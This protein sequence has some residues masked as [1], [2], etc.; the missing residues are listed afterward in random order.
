MLSAVCTNCQHSSSVPAAGTSLATCLPWFHGVDRHGGVQVIGRRHHD[1]VKVLALAQLLPFVLRAGVEHGSVPRVFKL[2]R[3][4]L[5]PFGPQVAQGLDFNPLQ[6]PQK[7]HVTRPPVAH[8]NNAHAH[9]ADPGRGVARHVE[10]LLV[11]CLI[12]AVQLRRDQSGRARA[13]RRRVPRRPWLT[14]PSPATP[15][16]FKKSL[17]F[18]FISEK[19]WFMPARGS[20]GR[21]ALEFTPQFCGGFEDRPHLGIADPMVHVDATDAGQRGI[22]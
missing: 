17:R 5:D 2:L 7:V 13:L 12:L 18:V 8:P 20:V 11:R 3:G 9:G 16:N 19:V 22:P 14:K 10:S 6:A 4:R 15:V 1:Q 21:A